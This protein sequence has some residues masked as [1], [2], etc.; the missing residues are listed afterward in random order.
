MY[1]QLNHILVSDEQLPENIILVNTSDWQ[2]Q[3][4][5]ASSRG[6]VGWGGPR[7]TAASSP[8]PVGRPA[9][10]HAARGVHLLR[11]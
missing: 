2:G 8:V 9:A 5:P 6:G 10:A 11:G 3:V 1:D 7:P 4:G